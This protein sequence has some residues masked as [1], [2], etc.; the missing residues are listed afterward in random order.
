MDVDGRKNKGQDQQKQ[1]IGH[2]RESR[3]SIGGA[4]YERP[5]DAQCYALRN[6]KHEIRQWV[7]ERD[8]E[9]TGLFGS[10]LRMRQP[11]R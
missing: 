5:T 8:R 1:E 7:Q 11:R 9:V 2:G 6:T 10:G 4:R 3:D